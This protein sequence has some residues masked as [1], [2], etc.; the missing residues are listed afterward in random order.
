METKPGQL[1]PSG[2]SVLHRILWHRWISALMVMLLISL[3]Y[4]FVIWPYSAPS[5]PPSKPS[6]QSSVPQ[7]APSPNSPVLPSDPAQAF[8]TWIAKLTIH[9]SSFIDSVWAAG[10]LAFLSLLISA[11]LWWRY[12]RRNEVPEPE[13][14]PGAGPTWA[15]LQ[16]P[17]KTRPVLLNSDALHST[18]WGVERFV[19]EDETSTVDLDRTVAAT[20]IAGGLPTLRFAHAVYPREV[21]LWRDIM[22]QDPTVD[23]ILNEL[24]S[25][26]TRAGL[27]V[28]IGTFAETPGLIAWHEGQEFSPLVVEGHRQSALVGILTDGYGMRLA[29]QSELEKAPLRQMLKAFGEWPRLTF[30]EVGDGMYGLAKYV[31]AYGLRCITLQDIP[32]FLAASPVSAVTLRRRE[33]DLFGELRAWAAATALSPEPVAE[34]RAFALQQRLELD[35]SLWQFRDILKESGSGDN[36][37][38]WSPARRAE[39]L[40]WLTRCSI[41][42]GKVAK[43]SLLARALDYW[44]AQYREENQQRRERENSLLPWRQTA[45]EQYMRMEVALLELWYQPVE[46]IQ[47]LYRL[48][49]NLSEEI[50]ERLKLLGDWSSGAQGH[51]NGCQASPGVVYLPWKEAELPM[52]VRWLL[53]QMGFGGR[54]EQDAGDL[55]MPVKLSLALGLCMGLALVAIGTAL[56]RLMGH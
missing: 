56:W 27:P 51:T 43:E 10:T 7:T 13:A 46:A 24:E 2:T 16:S 21:W 3:C 22:V 4:Y 15:P 41:E 30:V 26:L 31:Q 38:A 36:R 20:V 32:S 25:G 6:V 18:V 9:K 49:D 23:R 50:R 19:S 5:L 48:Y 14:S 17:E 55:H 34:E 53:E 37:I 47:A 40:N 44:I 12:R 39:L 1:T 33:S 45:A 54:A 35:L 52:Q 29:A 11:F 28:R 42:N 8:W